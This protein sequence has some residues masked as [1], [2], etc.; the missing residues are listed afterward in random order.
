LQS[1]KKTLAFLASIGNYFR[2]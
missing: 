1:V 2:P